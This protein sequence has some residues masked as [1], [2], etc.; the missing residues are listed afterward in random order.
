MDQELL[1]E[2]ILRQFTHEH[3]RHLLAPTSQQLAASVRDGRI[4]WKAL[5][6]FEFDSEDLPDVETVHELF[7]QAYPFYNRDALDPYAAWLLEELCRADYSVEVKWEVI[8]DCI[9]H[10][11]YMGDAYNP[12][13]DDGRTPKE[14]TD[15]YKAKTCARP[16]PAPCQN[17]RPAKICS[18][19]SFHVDILYG[20]FNLQ[21]VQTRAYR[22][23][24]P[25]YKLKLCDCATIQ[26]SPPKKVL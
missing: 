7:A 9:P 21:H 2:M 1:L 23:N 15:A 19:A 6:E 12:I 24:P 26:S 14:V 17:M 5:T 22:F 18:L 3:A 11:E 8:F 13:P 16:K 20:I 25:Q 10:E 4:P